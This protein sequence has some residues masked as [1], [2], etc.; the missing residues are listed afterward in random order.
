M[1]S[2]FVCF[3]CLVVVIGFVTTIPEVSSVVITSPGVRAVFSLPELT[4]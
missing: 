3:S 2:F 4:N 1:L